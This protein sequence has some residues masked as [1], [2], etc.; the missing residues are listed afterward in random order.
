MLDERT[1]KNYMRRLL[2][3]G[4]HI[5]ARTG[6]VNCTQLAEDALLEF[7][8]EWSSDFDSEDAFEF[9]FQVAEEWETQEVP[10]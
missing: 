8:D 6:E 2:Q 10:A 3:N 9:A 5:D 7:N 1:T 4:E